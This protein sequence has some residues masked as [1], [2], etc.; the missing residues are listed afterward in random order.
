MKLK[1]AAAR[2]VCFPQALAG[3]SVAVTA[4]GGQP[5]PYRSVYSSRFTH[6]LFN[7]SPSSRPAGWRETATCATA[8]VSPVRARAAGQ[9]GDW[10]AGGHGV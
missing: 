5:G 6:V 3:S 4:R 2:S 10:Q 8:R 7:A 9:H 1:G